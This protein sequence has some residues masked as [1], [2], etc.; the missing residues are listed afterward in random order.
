MRPP[1]ALA[2]MDDLELVQHVYALVPRLEPDPTYDALAN[3]FYWALDE[4]IERFAPDVARA[5]L[6]VA[7]RND[8]DRERELADVVAAMEKRAALR[9]IA[10]ALRERGVIDG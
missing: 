6:E 8:R 10:A 4:L 1:D 5:E 9:K 2:G 3:D 7:Y